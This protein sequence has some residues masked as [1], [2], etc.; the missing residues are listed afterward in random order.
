MKAIS[1]FVFIE[2]KDFD[3]NIGLHEKVQASTL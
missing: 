2:P 3:P 1:N